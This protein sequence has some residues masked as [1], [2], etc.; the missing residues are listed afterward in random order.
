MIGPATNSDWTPEQIERA[1]ARLEYDVSDEALERG[2]RERAHMASWGTP[3]RC[4]TGQCHPMGDC[5]LCG[6]INGEDCR[7]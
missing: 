4:K 7:R 1:R 3:A 6:A 5:L 2:R